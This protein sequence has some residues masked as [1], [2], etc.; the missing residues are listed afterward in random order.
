MDYS[1]LGLSAEV[2]ASSFGRVATELEPKK[3]TDHKAAD[4]VKSLLF[5]IANNIAQIAYLNA[6]KY[7]IKRVFFAGGFI[8][9]GPYLWSR[10]SYAINFW[11]QKTMEPFFLLHDGYLGALGAIITRPEQKNQKN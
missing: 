4:V 9:A 5:M 10:F 1:K 8:Q 11:S 7:N 6:Q 2:I 3:C